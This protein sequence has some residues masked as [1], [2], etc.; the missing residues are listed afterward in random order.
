VRPA[1]VTDADMVRLAHDI[2]RKISEQVQNFPG[3]IKVNVIR[4]L[5]AH[6]YAQ[7]KNE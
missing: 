4:E 2:S 5:R 3:Q 7:P 6:A 1:E